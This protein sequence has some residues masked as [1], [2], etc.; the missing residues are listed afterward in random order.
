MQRFVSN[1]ALLAG[2]IFAASLAGFGAA[3][4]AYSQLQH[5]AGML[6]A[7]LVPRATA[8]NLAAFVLPG[9]VAALACWGLRSGLGDAGWAARLGAQALLL[10]ALAFAAQGL[11][12]LDSLDLDGGRSR[13]HAAAW[14]AWWIAFAVG[15]GLLRLGT[16]RHRMRANATAAAACAAGTLAF[17]LLAPAALPAGLAQRIAFGFWFAAIWLAGRRQP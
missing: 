1:A 13:L 4:D 8:F 5:P 14:T 12:P 6:G 17:A 16:A 9:L 10:S 15:A 2:A 7:S 3:F 11:L